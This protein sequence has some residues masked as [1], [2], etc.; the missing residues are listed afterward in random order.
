[1]N[2]RALKTLTLALLLVALAWPA[3]AAD[4]EDSPGYVDLDFIEIPDH[5][6]EV[7]DI[8]L[9]A[10]L[11]TIADDAHAEGDQ[12]LA[13]MLRMVR[14]VRAKFYS[15]EAGDEDE[16]RK[17]VERVM[18]TLDDE[19][20]TRLIYIKDED[21]TVTVS[22]RNLAGKIVGLTVVMFE[23]GEQAG[24]VNVVGD[25]DLARLMTMAGEF[26][27]DDLEGYAERYGH[28]AGEYRHV[29]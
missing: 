16:A 25:I 19:D 26:D 2:T 21:E 29:E 3:P 6:R 5:A 8:D 14:S 28:E 22:T 24:F 15:L 17:N 20:W 23:P 18:K 11:D 27:L 10:M 4:L 7:Q 1:M 13:E 12:E 9:T